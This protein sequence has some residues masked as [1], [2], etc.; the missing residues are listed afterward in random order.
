MYVS[1]ET[2]QKAA[3][4]HQPDM[5]GYL[6]LHGRFRGNAHCSPDGRQLAQDLLKKGNCAPGTHSIQ[7]AWFSIQGAW[8]SIQGAWFSVQAARFSQPTDLVRLALD[9]LEVRI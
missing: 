4:R 8:F 2:V 3:T 7:G 9:N 5:F 1:Y 6:S